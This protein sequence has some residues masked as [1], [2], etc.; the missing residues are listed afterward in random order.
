M[1][2]ASRFPS[3]LAGSSEVE[4]MRHL[5]DDQMEEMHGLFVAQHQ[6][7]KRMHEPEWS[8]KSVSAEARQVGARTEDQGAG[9]E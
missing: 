5:L 7:N 3:L 6:R 8:S 1:A 9:D 2:S 4:G